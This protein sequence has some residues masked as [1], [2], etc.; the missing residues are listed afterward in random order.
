MTA[1]GKR[2]SILVVGFPSGEGGVKAENRKLTFTAVRELN[3]SKLQIAVQGETHSL[4]SG[5]SKPAYL[6]AQ[7]QL[8]TEAL[9]IMRKLADEPRLDYDYPKQR[10]FCDDRLVASRPP[11]SERLEFKHATLAELT[12]EYKPE[13]IEEARALVRKEREEKR[14]RQ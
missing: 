3:A 9:N 4:W 10:V 8:V 1:P 12:R 14:A 6:R 2:G 13:K 5:P 11:N 7:D